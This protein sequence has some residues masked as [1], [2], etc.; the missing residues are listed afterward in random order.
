VG[1]HAIQDVP[2]YNAQS[3]ST[4]T[5][6]GSLEPTGL[7][8]IITSYGTPNGKCYNYRTGQP[9]SCF[10][11][12]SQGGCL[13]SSP[14]YANGGPSG[15]NLTPGYAP[16]GSPAA[17]AGATWMV[18][19]NGNAAEMN[20]TR[21]I[22]SSLALTDEWRPNDRLQADAGIRVDQF[23]YV[24]S[25]LESDYPARQFWFDAYNNEHCG[26]LGQA[27]QYTWNG[28]SFNPCATGFLPFTDPG[29]GLSNSAG[30]TFAHAVF[31]PRASFTYSVN[32]DTVIRGSLGKYAGTA[33]SNYYQYN[34]EQQNLPAFLG[35]FYEAGYHTPDHDVLPDT[36]NNLD[37]SFEQHV[38]GTRFSYKVTPFYRST[39][40]QLQFQNINPEQGIYAQV[41][42]GEQQ[43]YGLELQ[44][45]YGDFN[46]DGFSSLLSY[47]HTNSEIRFVPVNGVSIV[48]SFNNQIELYNSYTA[49]CAGVTRS[50]SNWQ[51][52]GSGAYAGNAA[53]NLPYQPSTASYPRTIPNPY[54]QRSLQPLLNPNGEYAPYDLIPGPFS[55]ANGY[56]VPDVATLILN[57]RHRG[58]A[59]TPSLRYIDGSNYGAPLVYPGY[60]P[61]SCTAPPANTPQTPGAT[62]NGTLANG[63]SIG[64]IFLP[65]PYTG[66]FDTLGAFM[67]PSE[68]SVNL[69]LSYDLSPR[70]MITFQAVNL[71]NFC[72]QRGY[73]WDNSETCAYSNLPSQVLAP[74]GNFVTDPPLAL[75][76]P[77]G[78]YF[79]CNGAGFS[80]VTQPFDFFVTMTLKQL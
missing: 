67:Q 64:A 45:Q 52:C 29:V 68:L 41:N 73:A 55:G 27:P 35:Q 5:Q 39:Q 40:N 30:N 79:N 62:C 26:A 48:S 24:T 76:Y 13:L 66:K 77:Y 69:Q 38:A 80:A 44:L 6:P 31:Q 8:T 16:P 28:S 65:D 63:Q 25:D 23:V 43:S 61:Q 32:S 1:S 14:C 21:P 15:I 56:E 57:Y 72:H 2:S 3:T 12:G 54:Y 9:W 11:A 47:A 18:T 37:L 19:E 10:S 59:I 70:L 49:A 50:S 75:R 34:T 22:F 42:A 53:P 17:L 60:V 7:G 20:T 78:T 74:S 4:G 51:A 33:G 58:F 46:R 71:V 36:S